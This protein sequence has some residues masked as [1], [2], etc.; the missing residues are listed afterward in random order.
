MASLYVLSFSRPE[1]SYASCLRRAKK[2]RDEAPRITSAEV[3]VKD[4][5]TEN[6]VVESTI[7]SNEDSLKEETSPSE[8]EK[9]VEDHVEDV[10]DKV[11]DVIEDVVDKFKAA[12]ASAVSGL[13]DVVD[14]ITGN[15]EEE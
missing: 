1:L 9:K 11:E 2:K 3:K 7:E 12:A 6:V 8:G 15:L 4:S 14:S 5:L 10:L 13:E